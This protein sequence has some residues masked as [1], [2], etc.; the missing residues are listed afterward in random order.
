MD[1]EMKRAEEAIE[2]FS[3]TGKLSNGDG[4]RIKT[5]QRKNLTYWGYVDGEMGGLE[6]RENRGGVEAS[7]DRSVTNRGAAFAAFLQVE[8]RRWE[9][10]DRQIFRAAFVD[11]L[12]NVEIARRLF[13]SKRTVERQIAVIKERIAR[14]IGL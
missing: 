6:P 1:E 10:R 8:F 9:P 14:V 11:K 12:S 2:R 7:S 3:K 13:L 4:H 5:I